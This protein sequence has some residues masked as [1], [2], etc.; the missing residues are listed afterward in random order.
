MKQVRSNKTFSASCVEVGDGVHF[1]ISRSDVYQKFNTRISY[2]KVLKDYKNFLRF[3]QK[4]VIDS[5]PV[6]GHVRAPQGKLA[7]QM[8]TI[9]P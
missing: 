2:Q 1:I 4:V 8:L 6:W 5:N 3:L 7:L 9:K